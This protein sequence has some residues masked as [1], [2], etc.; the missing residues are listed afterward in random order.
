MEQPKIPKINWLKSSG[1]FPI[2]DIII[3]ILKRPLALPEGMEM[4]NGG[5][6]NAAP[7]QKKKNIESL[8]I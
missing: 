2:T 5:A 1:F 4:D 3:R 6:F 8:I 7:P